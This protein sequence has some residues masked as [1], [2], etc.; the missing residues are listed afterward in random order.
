MILFRVGLDNRNSDNRANSVQLELELGLSLAIVFYSRLDQ[1]VHN[2]QLFD[3]FVCIDMDA[4]AKVGWDIIKGDPHLTSQNGQLL[5]DFGIRNNLII[6]NAS[7]LR[8]GKIA[9]KRNTVNGA[10]EEILDYIIL[11]QEMFMF[12]KLMKIKENNG[13]TSYSRKKITLSDHRLLIGTFNFP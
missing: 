13:L 11:C 2:A 8:E 9:R 12:L 3:C 1:E 5:L 4:N 7:D 10:E 6:C